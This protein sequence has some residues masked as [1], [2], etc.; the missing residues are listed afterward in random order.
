MGRLKHHRETFDDG[1]RKPDVAVVAV[2]G[3]FI[4]EALF[5]GILFDRFDFRIAFEFHTIRPRV[6]EIEIGRFLFR[7]LIMAFIEFEFLDEGLIDLGKLLDGKR[8]LA[9]VGK[10]ENRAVVFDLQ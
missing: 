2:V 5:I 1:F 10:K 9:S 3:G 8:S 7:L 6:V 4:D